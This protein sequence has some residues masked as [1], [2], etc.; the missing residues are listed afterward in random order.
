MNDPPPVYLPLWNSILATRNS[1]HRP[2]PLPPGGVNPPGVL[3][4]RR[5][6]GIPFPAAGSEFPR[7]HPIPARKPSRLAP[8]GSGQDDRNIIKFASFAET[9]PACPE[10]PGQAGL[11]YVWK[12]LKSQSFGK[13]GWNLLYYM[14]IYV[15]SR[16]F[17][18]VCQGPCRH[19]STPVWGP[20][21]LDHLR[22]IIPR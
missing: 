15:E 14:G 5:E 4:F 20:R 22:A 13:R 2:V 11:D 6:R 8:T 12:G 1:G 16:S 10:K 21:L 18:I 19:D 17:A 7:S 3:I 9:I